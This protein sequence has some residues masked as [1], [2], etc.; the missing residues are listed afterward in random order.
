MLN[1]REGPD[2]VAAFN[3][4]QCH[5]IQIHNSDDLQAEKLTAKVDSELLVLPT[6][7]IG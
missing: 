1:T 7:S 2:E 5:N 4:S 3:L 6:S